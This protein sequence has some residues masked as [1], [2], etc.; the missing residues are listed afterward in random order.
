MSGRGP[1]T[2]RTVFPS[3]VPIVVLG[4]LILRQG[5]Q[6]STTFQGPYKSQAFVCFEGL[7]G[8][9][10]RLWIGNEIGRNPTLHPTVI[11]GSVLDAFDVSI[12]G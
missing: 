9:S 11:S 2:H 6:Q 4:T 7:S 1:N 5:P 3:A 8:R 12:H 10:E